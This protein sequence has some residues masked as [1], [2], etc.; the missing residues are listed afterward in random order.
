[1]TSSSLPNGDSVGGKDGGFVLTPG[2]AKAV[3][4]SNFMSSEGF[5]DDDEEEGG[6][7]L[8]AGDVKLNRGQAD[9]KQVLPPSVAEAEEKIL[10][11]ISS[12]T[13][14]NRELLE[15]CKAGSPS[16]VSAAAGA[17]PALGI[18]FMFKILKFFD[19]ATALEIVTR[20]KA[21]QEA[22]QET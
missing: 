18:T 21:A 7:A 14:A 12:I 6:V 17:D 11:S 22:Q 5:W 8:H 16:K 2:K 15:A 20:L 4:A 13:S 19:K 1:M 3:D 10:A 9:A